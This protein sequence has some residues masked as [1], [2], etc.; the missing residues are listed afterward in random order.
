MWCQTSTSTNSGSAGSRLSL[1]NLVS[2]FTVYCYDR[3]LFVTVVLLLRG[4]GTASCYFL[5][6]IYS[7][8][9]GAKKR[10]RR[11][12][13]ERAQKVGPRPSGGLLRPVVRCQTSKY[14]I[15]VRAGRGFTHAE[16]AAAGINRRVARTIGIAVD[17]RRVNRSA[18]SL[19]ANVARLKHH[20]AHLVVF[21]RRKGQPKNGDSSAEDIAAATQHTGVLQPIT[22]AAAA[23][24]EFV[25][26]SEE[27]SDFNA[28]QKLRVERTSAR[29]IGKKT[30]KQIAAEEAAKNPIKGKK[31]KK[32]K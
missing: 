25:E 26:I 12:R 19:E 7:N 5:N 27:L 24:P 28:F 1:T 22:A 4:G 29:Y 9:A 16:L 15:R 32:K 23:A 3:L 11:N 13:V 17:H 18:E 8:R 10:R 6:V 21:P 20:I 2:T 30:K 14:N 31:K